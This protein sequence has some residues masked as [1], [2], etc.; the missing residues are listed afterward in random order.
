MSLLL[1]C[2]VAEQKHQTSLLPL[3]FAFIKHSSS[4]YLRFMIS[5]IYGYLGRIHH[6]QSYITLNL[7]SQQIYARDVIDEFIDIRRPTIDRENLIQSRS[8]RWPLVSFSVRPSSKS[9]CRIMTRSGDIVAIYFLFRDS[10]H[11]KRF[12]S[13]AS[14]RL[15]A[16]KI[17]RRIVSP[18]HQKTRQFLHRYYVEMMGL[19]NRV[20][21]YSL[22]KISL[23]NSRT[24]VQRRT[25]LCFSGLACG[26]AFYQIELGV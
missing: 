26:R 18:K 17:Q 12:G 1:L 20:L 14:L 3:A 13:K 8:D 21:C 22:L 9:F 15:F 5:P 2:S 23:L 24:Y 6:L 10:L 11:A 7:Q 25:I 16:L 19:E 4:S